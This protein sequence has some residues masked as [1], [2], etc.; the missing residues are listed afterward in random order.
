[1]TRAGLDRLHELF[2]VRYPF[3]KFDQAFVPEFNGGAMENA[4]PG[5]VAR[6]VPVPLGG[7]R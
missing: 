1:M 6:R 5:R 7:R 4:G 2:G 3:D